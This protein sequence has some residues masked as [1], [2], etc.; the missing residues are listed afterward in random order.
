MLFDFACGVETPERVPKKGAR[1]EGPDLF[2]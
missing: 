2:S 1:I